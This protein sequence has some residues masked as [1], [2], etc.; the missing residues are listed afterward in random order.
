MNAPSVFARL[1]SIC[2]QG[3]SHFALSYLDDILIFSET[4]QEHMQHLQQVFDRLRQHKLKLKLSKC[5]FIQDQTKYLGFI[6]DKDGIKPDPD[7]VTAIKTM[8][9]PTTVKEV[10]AFIGMCSWYRRFIPNFSGIAGPLIEL[11]KKYARFNWTEPCQS[12]FDFLKDSLTIVANLAHADINKPYILYTDA[13]QNAIG[14]VLVQLV[15]DVENGCHAKQIEKPIHFLSHR[16]SPTQSKYS[17]IERECYAIYY[18]TQKIRS[19]FTQRG[20]HNSD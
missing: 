13:S 12:A 1:M 8:S 17:C 19:L 6:V 2:L 14:A 16:L 10:R 18:A 15:D 11:T 4:E 5:N 20:C 9:A 3:L 7:K